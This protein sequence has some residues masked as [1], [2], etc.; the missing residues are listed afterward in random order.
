MTRKECR[1]GVVRH[2]RSLNEAAALAAE[3]AASGLTRR[4]FC[5]GRD[6]SLNT[7][8]RYLRRYGDARP[9]EAQPLI[10][11]DVTGAAGFH[12]EVA[13]V[14]KHGRKVEVAKG[15]DA[16][17]LEQVVRVLERF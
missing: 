1:T 13:V 12:A 17:T 10:R 6:V 5:E 7:L 9:E 3:F 16:A 15:F 8:N 14:L 11:I 2:Y 4:Q